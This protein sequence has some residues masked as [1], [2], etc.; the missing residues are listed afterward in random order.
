M[1]ITQYTST[2]SITT[3]YNHPHGMNTYPHSTSQVPTI[4]SLIRL[5]QYHIA[6]QA[7]VKANMLLAEDEDVLVELSDCLKPTSK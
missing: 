7:N 3:E 2:T 6:I 4:I 1:T 5:L